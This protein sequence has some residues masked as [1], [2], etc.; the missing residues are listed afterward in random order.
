[1]EEQDFVLFLQTHVTEDE[2][3]STSLL[4]LPLELVQDFYQIGHKESTSTFFF[5]YVSLKSVTKLLWSLVCG[6]YTHVLCQHKCS[7]H[8][9]QEEPTESNPDSCD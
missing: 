9:H 5:F 6:G 7:S 4:L 2:L 1:M 3:I 8:L